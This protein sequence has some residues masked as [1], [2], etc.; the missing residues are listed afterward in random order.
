MKVVALGPMNSQPKEIFKRLE[1]DQERNGPVHR[2]E[3]LTKVE[4]KLGEH[5]QRQECAVVLDQLVVCETDDD[6]D[7]REHHEPHQLDRFTAD[8][9]HQCHCDPVS[10]DRAGADD[11]QITNSGV[12]EDFVHRV[13]FRVADRGQD[14]GIVQA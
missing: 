8:C 13:S 14:D 6:E 12:V 9:V 10:R 1:L 5:V 7:D 4:E 11:D 2:Q 3:R